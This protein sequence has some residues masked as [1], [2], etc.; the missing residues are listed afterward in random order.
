MTSPDHQNARRA[1]L[2]NTADAQ[3]L[4]AVPLGVDTGRSS[5]VKDEDL[6]EIL[7]PLEMD[8]E[9]DEDLLVRPRDTIPPVS[10]LSLPRKR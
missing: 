9:D 10:N 1:L 2:D 3:P 5:G 7:N 4:L 6:D 8:L